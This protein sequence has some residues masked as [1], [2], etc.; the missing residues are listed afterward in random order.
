[1]RTYTHG[2][3]T[4]VLGRKLAEKGVAVDEK[5]FLAGAVVPDIPFLVLSSWY[6]FDRRWRR[7]YLP[8]ETLCS[9][10][11]NWLFR[12][13]PWWIFTYNVL[14]APLVLLLLAAVGFLGRR[15]PWGRRLLW[16]VV[17]CMGHTGID[18]VTHVD[19]GPLWQF[20][21]DWQ[22]RWAAPV[23]YWDEAHGGRWMRVVEH[24]LDVGLLLIWWRQVRRARRGV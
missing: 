8:D 5:A 10:T 22:T 11:Y 17:A 1:M 7:P 24:L 2:L 15:R 18:M 9:P 13:D 19:D 12:N 21:F 16:F 20:P 3:L 6:S 4:A 14:H 23:S